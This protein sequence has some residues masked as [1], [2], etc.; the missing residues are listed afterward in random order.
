MA[1]SQLDSVRKSPRWAQRLKQFVVPGTI[2][3]MAAGIL[4][5]D[6]GQLEYLGRRA[7]F[8][9]NR[10]RIRARGPDSAEH[11][12]GRTGGHGRGF[13]L[14]TGESGRS[15]GPVAG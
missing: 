10:R 12:G 5:S 1:D 4:L 15:T 8:P 13:R 9:K 6:R 14:S 3:L 2:L 11:Q 7:G